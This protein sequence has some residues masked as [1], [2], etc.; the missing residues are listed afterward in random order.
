MLV[1]TMRTSQV[2]G[3]TSGGYRFSIV[4]VSHPLDPQTGETDTAHARVSFRLSWAT[5]A[6]PG[7]RLCT[8][9]VYDEAGA[10]VGEATEAVVAAQES[11]DQPAYN[12]VAVAGEPARADVSCAPVRLDD[13]AGHFRVSNARV[14]TN[15]VLPTAEF[16]VV[17]DAEW[18]GAGTTT[19]QECTARLFGK[20]GRR[21]HEETGN[22]IS[23]DTAPTVTLQL[24]DVPSTLPEEPARATVTCRPLH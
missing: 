12:D 2:S 10:V 13:P 16:A 21:L 4:D 7:E 1:W 14:T 6:F 20:S 17:F 8:W 18:Q 22:L 19:P 11:Y 24:E 9:Q 3:Q 5:P 23:A 15:T